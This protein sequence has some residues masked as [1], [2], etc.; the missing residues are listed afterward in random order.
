MEEMYTEEI[1]HHSRRKGSKRAYDS[2]VVETPCLRNVGGMKVAVVSGVSKRRLL[3]LGL[4][5]RRGKKLRSLSKSAR[6][7]LQ[8]VFLRIGCCTF[9]A[10]GRKQ[11]QQT[12][13]TSRGEIRMKFE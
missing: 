5:T 6:P 11:R 3:P 1:I 9:S 4:L 10:A 2:R 13:I 7:F 8:A 12:Q